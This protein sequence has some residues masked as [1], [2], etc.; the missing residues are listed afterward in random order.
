MFP[1]NV[2]IHIHKALSESVKIQLNKCRDTTSLVSS[3]SLKFLLQCANLT[4]NDVMSAV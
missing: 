4:E 3:L 1:E 2:G